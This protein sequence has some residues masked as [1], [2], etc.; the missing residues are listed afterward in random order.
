MYTKYKKYVMY[1][2]FIFMN[3]R[4]Q[5]NIIYMFTKFNNS[6]IWIIQLQ[7]LGYRDNIEV[8]IYGLYMGAIL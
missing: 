2:S 6:I 1:F 8:E 7:H 4:N 5:Y 3:K